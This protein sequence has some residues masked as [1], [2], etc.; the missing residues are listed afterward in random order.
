VSLLFW[1]PACAGMTRISAREQGV[2]LRDLCGLLFLNN[3]RT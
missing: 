2:F 1:F 3:L